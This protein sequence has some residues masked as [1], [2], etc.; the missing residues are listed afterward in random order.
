MKQKG[1]LK[2]IFAA[3]A[4]VLVVV[5]VLNNSGA[6]FSDKKTIDGDISVPVIQ[7]VLYTKNGGG[8]QKVSV[9]YWNS[10]TYNDTLSKPIYFGF[11]TNHNVTGLVVRF[12]INVEW[13]TLNGS[14]FTPEAVEIDCRILKPDGTF[15]SNF[16]KGYQADYDFLKEF[17]G[18]EYAQ[19]YCDM[20]PTAYYYNDVLSADAN[21]LKNT[22]YPIYNGLIFDSANYPNYS[23]KTARI[24]F[25]IEVDFATNITIGETS[26]STLTKAGKWAPMESG[27]RTLDG[28][29]VSWIN[30][31]KT[32]TGYKYVEN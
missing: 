31:I 32:K 29:P 30:S 2:W 19:E 22:K 24:T 23:T 3:L 1:K 21:T 14:T 7:P 20:M 10:T 8:Y 6:W 13:G 5:S 11:D 16:T 9:L 17:F 25:K 4:V 27:V 28:A 26:G 18:E 12:W 15:T